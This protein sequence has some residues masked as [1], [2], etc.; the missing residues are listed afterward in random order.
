MGSP[1]VVDV[2]WI[3]HCESC[4]NVFKGSRR[5]KLKTEVLCTARGVEQSKAVAA[6]LRSTEKPLKIFSSFLPRAIETAALIA[7]EVGIE[8][9]QVLCNIAEVPDPLETESAFCTLGTE[10]TTT[11]ASALCFAEAITAATGVNV[12]LPLCGSSEE[13]ECRHHMG[14]TWM[15][16]PSDGF[17]FLDSE[18]PRFNTAFLNVVVSHGRYIGRHVLQREDRRSLMSPAY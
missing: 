5:D 10:D 2:L 3:R 4:A 11:A 18:L 15:Y 1:S 13:A 6:S 9:V 14:R 16:K 12:R 7:A 17:R 8:E